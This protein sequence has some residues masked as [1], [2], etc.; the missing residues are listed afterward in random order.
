MAREQE[1]FQQIIDANQEFSQARDIDLLLEKILAVAY[2]LGNAEAGAMYVNEETALRLHHTQNTAAN[3]RPGSKSNLYTSLPS[4]KPDSIAAYVAQTGEF[5]AIADPD[6]L[7]APGPYKF[8]PLPGAT[9]LH[10]QSILAFPLRDSNDHT[11]A[12][13][14]LV[15]IKNHQGEIITI[16]E[17]DLPLV[18]LFANNASIAVERARATRVRITGILQVLTM[19]RNTEETLGHFNRVGAYASEIYESWAYSKRIDPETIATQK[20]LL[21]TAAMLHDIGKL[22]VPNIIRNKP[23]KLT[24]EEYAT[25]KQHTVKGA[26]LLLK[27]AQSDLEKAAA[28][29]ALNH[30]EHWDGSGY[31]GYVNPETETLLSGTP[32]TTEISQGKKGEDIPLFGRIVAIADAYD[33]LLSQR[34]Y[35]EAWKE[36]DVLAELKHGAGHQYDPD[37]IAAFFASLETLRAIRQRYPD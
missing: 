11:L 2:T 27:Y 14:E 26:Q 25:M 34:V 22:A 1:K 13:I 8:Y 28:E 3:S 30:H 7:P 4:V 36:E 37:M 5:V 17:D 35:R 29:I 31:P 16:S 19:L 10:V 21:R 9:H 32:G 33:A 15:N 12:V 24:P 20:D 18:R 23:G 6:L